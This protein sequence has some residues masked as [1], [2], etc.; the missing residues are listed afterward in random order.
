MN[1]DLLRALGRQQRDDLEEAFEHPPPELDELRRPFDED[2]RADILDRVF[3][4]IDA[5]SGA[6]GPALSSDESDSSSD[7]Q[8]S[9]SEPIQ[10]AS[11]RR[12]FV[13]T[14]VAAVAVAAG[15]LLWWAM[16]TRES[17]GLVATVPAYAFSHL[18]GGIA[19]QRSE[20]TDAAA[21]PDGVPELK[22]RADSNID[23]LLTPAKPVS[24]PIGVALLARS[25]AGELRFA[26]RLDAEVSDRGAVLLR[27]PLDR[28]I[29]LTPGSW[30][31]TLLV[32]EPELLPEGAA[33][34]AEVGADSGPWR[35]LELRVIIVGD[36]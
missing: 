35:R 21:S 30:A 4:Q 16:P 34:A 1:D 8:T 31:L 29:V 15:L 36:E 25:D 33:V 11:R 17:K 10:L 32:A 22:L 23:W 13:A 20:P 26:P 18:Q 9:G 6:T 5:S 28:Y 12:T 3:E 2:E 7:G 24:R 27:G 14:V 19:G